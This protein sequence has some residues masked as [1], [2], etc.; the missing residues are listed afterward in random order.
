MTNSTDYV[1]SKNM[2]FKRDAG[3]DMLRIL[4]MLMVVCIHTVGWGG[5]VEGALIP[6]TVNWYL[7]NA[8]QTLSLQAVNCFV[9]ISGYF[10]CTS[11]FRL[12][13][14]VFT[15]IQAAFYSVGIYLVMSLAHVGGMQFS[16]KE[17][18]KCTLV[19]TMDRYWFVTDYILLYCLFPI[20]NHAIRSMNQKQHFLSCAV[21]LLIFSVVPNIMYVIDFSGTNNGYS[22]TWFCILYLIAAYFRLYVPKRIKH[23]KWM[24]SAYVVLALTICAER[25]V[26]YYVTPFIFGRVALTS[27]FYS[28]NSIVAVP[29]AL[30]LFQ[31]FRGLEMKSGKSAAC[32]RLIAPLTFAVY[33]IHEQDHFR[34]ILWQWLN[35]AAFAQSPWMVPYCLLCVAGIFAV[36]CLIEWVRQQLFRVCGIDKLVGQVCDRV[37]NRVQT[38]L[39]A[40]E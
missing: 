19:V 8:M 5:L 14:L 3:L 29:C 27:L 11:P 40:D 21:L 23:Q 36:C 34:P 10:L 9:L 6:G 33:L 25:F 16:L 39:S 24:F 15:W 13:K 4:C 26:A 12:G 17:L 20:L 38:W 7:G 1:V 28:Y 35:P 2:T 32:I 30:A 22:L 37:Q 18:I 31:T